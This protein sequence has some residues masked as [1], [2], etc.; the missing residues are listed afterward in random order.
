[1]ELWNWLKPFSLSVKSH[2]RKHYNISEKS[3]DLR[4]SSCFAAQ[5]LLNITLSSYS[6]TQRYRREK[7][8]SNLYD[9]L[10]N[11]F[12]FSAQ[13]VDEFVHRRKQF[14]SIFFIQLVRSDDMSLLWFHEV[15][16]LRI[17]PI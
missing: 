4:S 7:L 5:S 6:R 1:M 17:F 12:A 14:L 16:V 10:N 11:Y 8:S 9:G 3:K 13:F 15:C 2:Q